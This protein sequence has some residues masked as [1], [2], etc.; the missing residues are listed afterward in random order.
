MIG[1]APEGKRSKSFRAVHSNKCVN[2]KLVLKLAL[3]KVTK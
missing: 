2:I 3:L 1:I